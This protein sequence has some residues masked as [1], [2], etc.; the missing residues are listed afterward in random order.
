MNRLEEIAY[1]YL[2]TL[3]SNNRV[4]GKR[5]GGRP[6]DS[7]IIYMFVQ[8]DDL[9]DRAFEWDWLDAEITMKKSDYATLK[10]M[11]GLEPFQI[12]KV[13]RLFILNKT[14]DEKVLN[15]NTPVSLEFFNN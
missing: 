5:K 6:L 14:K 2:N 9:K 12:L 7:Q 3:Y 13:M 4:T 1:N 11:F 15:T 10:N 8:G